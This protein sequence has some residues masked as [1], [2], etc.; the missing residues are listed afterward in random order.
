MTSTGNSW[1][2]HSA[3]AGSPALIRGHHRSGK[4]AEICPGRNDP[5]RTKLKYRTDPAARPASLQ[6]DHFAIE[7]SGPAQF[8]PGR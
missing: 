2:V 4:L 5:I 6:P 8:T 3:S 1:I 7:A